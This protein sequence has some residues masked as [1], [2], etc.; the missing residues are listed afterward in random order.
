MA[1]PPASHSGDALPPTSPRVGAAPGEC[2]SR[3]LF[4]RLSAASGQRRETTFPS[5]SG[6]QSLT[7]FEGGR[8]S[9]AAGSHL[10][11]VIVDGWSRSLVDVIRGRPPTREQ[12]VVVKLRPSGTLDA[13]AEEIAAESG[14]VSCGML[15]LLL[16]LMA[17][18]VSA[19]TPMLAQP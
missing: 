15:L 1:P 6:E 12:L 10:M 14:G 4:S 9:P 18:V 19:V 5:S 2:S 16:L 11:E 17:S 7:L 13:E 3:L 8:G